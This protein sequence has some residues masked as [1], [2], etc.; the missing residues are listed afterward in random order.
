MC[1]MPEFVPLAASAGLGLG[2]EHG[3]GDAAARERERDRAADHA[4][5]DDGDLNSPRCTG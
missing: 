4:G 1:R 3:H 5:A 2:L